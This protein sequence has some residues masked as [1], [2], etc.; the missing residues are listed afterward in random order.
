[1]ATE[2]SAKGNPKDTDDFV[3]DLK[4]WYRHLYELERQLNAL[5]DSEVKTPQGQALVKEFS[6]TVAEVISRELFIEDLRRKGEHLLP[7]R[8]PNDNPRSDRWQSSF[9]RDVTPSQYRR[10][11]PSHMDEGVAGGKMKS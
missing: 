5:S 8:R 9:Y 1:M 3:Q 7:T 2:A 4:H 10:G 11:L 6:Q